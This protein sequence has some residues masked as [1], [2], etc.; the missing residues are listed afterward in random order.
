MR[1]DCFA[2]RYKLFVAHASLHCVH[3][4]SDPLKVAHVICAATTERRLV[5]NHSILWRECAASESASKRL[6]LNQRIQSLRC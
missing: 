3:G 2:Q 6:L 4:L 5:I 1:D